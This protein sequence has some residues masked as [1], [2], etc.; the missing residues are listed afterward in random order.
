MEGRMIV[1]RRLERVSKAL[2][3]QEPDYGPMLMVDVCSWPPDDQDAFRL[4]TPEQ[5]A[6]L[7][8]G[9][10]GRRPATTGPRGPIRTIID[11]PV[12]LIDP[13]HAIRE[14]ERILHEKE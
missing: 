7:I 11:V 14:A 6:D 9:H 1:E 3:G 4:G 2:G 12:A 8:E 10:C 13:A 5:R